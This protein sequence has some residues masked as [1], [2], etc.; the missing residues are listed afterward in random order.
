[1][2]TA[3]VREFLRWTGGLFAFNAAL[4]YGFR[5]LLAWLLCRAGRAGTGA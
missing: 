2:S 3:A 4:D 1:M 5:F